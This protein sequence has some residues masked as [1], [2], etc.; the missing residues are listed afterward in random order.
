MRRSIP[1]CCAVPRGRGHRCPS[2]TS[3]RRR[4]PLRR[5]MPS[6]RASSWRKPLVDLFEMAAVGV[7]FERLAQQLARAVALAELPAHVDQ[8]GGNLRVLLEAIGPLEVIACGAIV[9]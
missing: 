1:R 8:M 2:V 3:R 5:A 4:A 6:R 9:A 7:R